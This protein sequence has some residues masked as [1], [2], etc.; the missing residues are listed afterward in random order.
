MVS[1]YSCRP[2]SHKFCCCIN[3]PQPPL[4]SSISSIAASRPNDQ[5]QYLKSRFVFGIQ[6]Q[7]QWVAQTTTNTPQP[8]NV[9]SI[10]M[11]MVC[12]C[13][14]WW[15][16]P[17][18]ILYSQQIEQKSSSYFAVRQGLLFGKWKT[19]KTQNRETI[20]IAFV[21]N[22]GKQLVQMRTESLARKPRH[23]NDRKN[24]IVFRQIFSIA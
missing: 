5:L 20:A 7:I 15:K 6:R 16:M 12:V 10:T 22:N 2:H 18:C 8:N 3:A 23:R 24:A 9:P 13:V 11:N 4:P 19:I 17:D 14:C 21:T 1:V